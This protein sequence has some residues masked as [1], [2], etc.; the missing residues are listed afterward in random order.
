MHKRVQGSARTEKK[1]IIEETAKW[2]DEQIEH[3][4]RAL[5]L[6][7]EQRFRELKIG[8][9]GNRT[10]YYFVYKGKVLARAVSYFSYEEHQWKFELV[11]VEQ[12]C[13][14]AVKEYYA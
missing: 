10:E 14:A 2:I 7:K 13:F 9:R 4:W 3:V 12:E 8:N 5:R 11:Q 1:T 6:E